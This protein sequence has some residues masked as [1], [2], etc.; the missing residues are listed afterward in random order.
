MPT[1]MNGLGAV[2]TWAD[3]SMGCVIR[4]ELNGFLG[5]VFAE[6]FFWLVILISFRLI[7]LF[8]ILFDDVLGVSVSAFIIWPTITFRF[9]R[10]VHGP[11]PPQAVL[12]PA[13]TPGSG[14]K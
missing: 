5:R 13:F 7:I 9:M 8:S 10:A 2:G 11:W 1:S 12:G 3:S 14:T 6:G 4:R